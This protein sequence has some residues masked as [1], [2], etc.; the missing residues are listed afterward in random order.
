MLKWL[1]IA[2][3]LLTALPAYG[4][5]ES[6]DLHIRYIGNAGFEI[7]DG[8]WTLLV[9]FPYRSGAHGYMT[10]DSGELQARDRSLCLF[11]HVHADHFDPGSLERISCAVAG[12]PEVLDFVDRSSW[13][14]DGPTWKF[15]QAAIRCLSTDHPPVEHCSYL[16][17][18]QSRTLFV[19][20]DVEELSGL[21]GLEGPIDTILLSAWLAPEVPRIRAR[22]PSARIIVS[23]RSARDDLSEC[24]ECVVPTQGHEID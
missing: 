22:Y 7:S 5:E 14:G 20:G 23:H 1:S 24:E 12:P 6:R 17:E 9:D 2:A 10:F 4:G 3:V 19:T 21:F 16:I 18:W 8:T 11:T 13:L 15:G